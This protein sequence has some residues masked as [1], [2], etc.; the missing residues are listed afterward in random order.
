VRAGRGLGLA[1]WLGLLVAGCSVESR[2]ALL[3]RLF[4]GVP[5]AG[6]A[7]GAPPT[8]RLRRDLLG[9]IEELKRALAE[10]REAL[11]TRERSPGLEGARR[12]AEQAKSWAEARALLPK[13]TEGEVDWVRALADGAIAPRPGLAPD[14]PRLAV[15][16][17]DVVIQS[18][19]AGE[20][21]ARFSH[22]THTPWLSCAN[23]HPAPFPLGRK[24]PP[25]VLTMDG[26]REGRACGA[27]H[28]P[29][30]FGVDG[31]CARCHPAMGGGK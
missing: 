6:P 13:G 16:D 5:E 3:P 21:A 11:K 1:L 15:L 17:L 24:A 29:V 28:G 12:P 14:A 19:G 20:S 30:A 26:L 18:Q 10:A 4:D 22:G 7:A 27:C 25:V 31:A 8:Q 23:C 9:E 2:Q